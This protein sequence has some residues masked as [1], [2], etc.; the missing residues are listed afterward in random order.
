MIVD[1]VFGA[2]G[3]YVVAVEVAS[4]LDELTLAPEQDPADGAG[5]GDADGGGEDPALPEAT[6]ITVSVSPTS[7]RG[8]LAAGEFDV[9]SFSG[10]P[11]RLIIEMVQDEGT[12]L[13]PLIVLTDE[14][15]Q[16]LD[17]ND[18]AEAD[19][20]LPLFASRLELD[21]PAGSYRIEARTFGDEGGGGYT[22]TIRF[23]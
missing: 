14:N 2:G 10:G 15:G 7:Q 22:I 5:D 17:M 4:S 6:P 13:D 16:E 18:D 19:A 9:Y 1:E 8:D 23:A 21:I 3:Q 12:D 20:G 11:E